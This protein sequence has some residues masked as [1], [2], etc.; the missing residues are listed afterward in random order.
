MPKNDT[1]FKRLESAT[2][3]ERK[4]ICKILK[5]DTN[6]SNDIE[7]IS[8]EFR[9]VSGHTIGNL[10]RDSHD[11]EYI[12][13]LR[14]TWIAVKDSKYFNPKINFSEE[15]SLENKL[16]IVFNSILKNTKDSKKLKEEIISLGK[17]YTFADV[18][19]G[20]TGVIG[21]FAKFISLPLAVTTTVAGSLT[22]PSYS[23]SFLVVAKLIDIKR[24]L[25]A[26][27][28]LKD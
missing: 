23:K 19:V 10:L 26:E 24:R 1:I 13:I 4:E 16:E 22:A 12:D 9:S 11:Y 17:M 3:V 18:L 14:T 8:A 6:N 27:E 7:K 5:M 28:K 25:R 20:S 15:R 21:I 2:E